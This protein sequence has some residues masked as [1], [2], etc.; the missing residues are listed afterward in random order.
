MA[1]K[2]A[3]EGPVAEAGPDDAW[4][5]AVRAATLFA[6]L[7]EL[8]GRSESA[9]SAVLDEVFAES[10]PPLA[11]RTDLGPWLDEVRHRFDLAL[12]GEGRS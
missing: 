6:V 5:D 7:L 9:I 10:A 4:G 8:Q 12:A 2:P 11:E 1:R 3:G